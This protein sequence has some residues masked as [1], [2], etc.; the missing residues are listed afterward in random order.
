MPTPR[1]PLPDSVL[2]MFKDQEEEVTDDSS[3]H[4]GRVRNFPHERGN[5][6]TYVYLPCRTFVGLEVSC[7]HSQ[8]LE[9]VSEV[10]KVME[11]FDLPTFYKNPSFHISL[12]WCA[13]DL[14]DKLEGQCLKELQ[15]IV[16]G[17]EDS[18]FLLRFQ[19]DQIRC[20]SGNKF[21]SF[22]L[23]RL[24][25]KQ[26]FRE[27][28][29]GKQASTLLLAWLRLYGY[30]PQ[31]SRQMSTMRSAQILAS[32]L[33]EMQRFYGITVTG[34]LDEE[35]KLIQNYT[36]KL[37]WYHSY[38]AIR[39]AFRVWEQA[40]PLVFQEVPYDDIRHKRRKEADIM[41]LF[42]SGFH[43]DSSP[44]DGVGGFLA[45]AYFPGPGMGG[46]THFDSDEPWTLE[47]TDVSG[48][49]LFLVA[50]HELGHSLGLEHSSNPS[51]IMAPFYQWMDTENF[52]LPEDDLKGIQ[53]LYGAPD[54]QPQP[55]RPLP[56]VTPPSPGKP[57]HRPPKPPPPGKPDRPPKPGN[58]DRPRTTDRPDQYGPNICD[59]EFDTVAVL[60][61]EMFVFKR[62]Q[63]RGK[64]S[65]HGDSAQLSL[66]EIWPRLGELQGG[67]RTPLSCRGAVC[68]RGHLF[69]RY[70][71]FNEETHSADPGY[72]KLITVWVGIPPTPKGAFLSSDASYTYFYKGTKYW[73]FDNER[74]KTEPGYPKSILRDF[75]GCHEALVPD[76][77]PGHR[78]PDLDRPPF[79]PDGRGTGDDREGD[80]G[81]AEARPGDREE[82]EEEEEEEEDYGGPTRGNGN[83]VDIVVQIDKYTR[84]MS[85]VM[86][87]VPLVLLLCVLGLIYAIIQMHRKGAPR[88]LLYC[89]R[90]LQE[91]V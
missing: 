52:Q 48:N 79:N 84:T 82:Q 7:G 2:N 88:M 29:K 4:G 87:M 83:D 33:S 35:T 6:A 49:N 55:T 32:A 45:H 5:W 39:R 37:G 65:G 24:Y 53:Q 58:P 78:W 27:P 69:G 31:S 15:E 91:W 43:G 26:S 73:K 60:R 20:R 56:T 11:E 41:V 21:F 50:I 18:T 81:E 76:P 28:E 1:L 77:D 30:L 16:D 36:D 42:A 22:P 64:G 19:W 89:K 59:G 71:R 8:L 38:E 74:L 51:A 62:S 13:G 57:D 54:G 47:N 85:I 67:G 68:S 25:P 44:F 63:C 80:E 61:G 14:T 34:V 10:D 86:V 12:A 17:F 72:P 75:M 70:W 40:T 23:R 3:K 46:D 66:P 90:S 9:L